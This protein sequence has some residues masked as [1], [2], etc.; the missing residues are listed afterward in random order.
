MLAVVAV[1]NAAAPDLPVGMELIPGGNAVY[2]GL[3]FETYG[4]N[5]GIYGPGGYPGT[6]L[7]VSWTP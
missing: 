7:G 4:G 6:S 3:L 5:R 1:T 2:K